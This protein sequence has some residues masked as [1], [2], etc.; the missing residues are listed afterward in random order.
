MSYKYYQALGQKA[1]NPVQANL[2]IS[3]RNPEFITILTTDKLLDKD[4][5]PELVETVKR[6]GPMYFDLDSKDIEESID[7]AK[8]LVKKLLE[9]G[10]SEDDICIHATG[11][12][13]FHILVPQSCFTTVKPVLRLH[14][15]YKEIAFKLATIATDF[16][17]YSGRMGR[18]WRTTYNQRAN[19]SF[20]VPV[21]HNELA[22]MTAE[23]YAELCSEQRPEFFQETG[24]FCP[25]FALVFDAALQKVSGIK[26][27]KA[28]FV[29]AQVMTQDAPAITRLLAGESTESYNQTFMQ[30][31]IY[32]VARGWTEDHLVSQATGLIASKGGNRYNNP[33]IIERELRNM[34]R[35][36]EGNSGYTYSSEAIR[37]L[38]PKKQSVDESTGELVEEEESFGPIFLTETAIF[39][40]GAENVKEILRFGVQSLRAVF[41]IPELIQKCQVE[42]SSQEQALIGVMLK[43][44]V[45]NG[46][47]PVSLMIQKSAF[48]GGG[49]LCSATMSAGVSFTGSDSDARNLFN[50]FMTTLRKTKAYT[51][52]A[53]REGLDLLKIPGHENPEIAQGFL[54]WVD[55]NGMKVRPGI[56]PD[57][58]KIEFK[59]L[60]DDITYNTDLSLLEP[61]DSW[62]GKHSSYVDEDATEVVSSS[63]N[64]E[65]LGLM[66]TDMFASNHPRVIAPILGWMVAAI[67]KQPIHSYD[68]KFPMLSVVGSAGLGKT[69]T[70]TTYMRLFY[71]NAEPVS[72]TPNSTLFG[73]QQM[74]MASASI[75]LICDEY[76]PSKMRA[77]KAEEFR[78]LLR[79]VY[80]QKQI[81]RGGGS[82]TNASWQG[83][84][85]QSLTA[86]MI[87]ISE[88]MET[89]S[90]IMERVV[91]ATFSK[92]NQ[93]LYQRY[94]SKY[95]SFK[96]RSHLL[97]HVGAEITEKLLVTYCKPKFDA[98]MRS[99]LAQAKDDYLP[100]EHL[101]A[102][103]NSNRFSVSSRTLGNYTVI[104]YGLSLLKDFLNRHFSARFDEDIERLRETVFPGM[105]ALTIAT[106]PEYLKLMNTF[107][108][109][110]FHDADDV[111]LRNNQEYVI[112]TTRQGKEIIDISVRYAFYR[113][114]L[115]CQKGGIS[116][117]FVSE[118]ALTSAM[119]NSAYFV[120]HGKGSTTS[121]GTSYLMDLTGMLSEGI[122]DFRRSIKK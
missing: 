75:P 113:Y 98:A 88:A 111:A 105:K 59:P 76:K 49:A 81:T 46:S 108:I 62:K 44:I 15:V 74:L 67:A 116:P 100:S 69:D 104:D 38:L 30:V 41:S 4:S 107:A 55:R 118:D 42:G 86:P 110:S 43:G 93:A 80:N 2:D 34:F 19:G 18:M 66:F 45:E 119:E 73:N 27:A 83:L 10:L 52:V 72:T 26:R 48:L 53:E 92:P 60:S 9:R 40:R 51:Y 35:Y 121:P 94:W 101:S 56:L 13:G 3:M 39:S 5:P 103:A 12:K 28:K 115:Y 17:V 64:L 117:L 37:D 61:F 97:A 16:R 102:E 8:E 90:A 57:N 11:S 91:L 89:E 87:V 79:E 1:W 68:G 23:S 7:C 120:N 99:A 14:E 24:K 29:S 36:L 84:N 114:R 122:T 47:G 109:M 21:T 63:T 70:I 96:R 112:T 54:A 85:K 58:L 20:K 78:A 50:L 32:A 22:E 25:E 82:R 77:E 33:R 31:A 65:E 106:L 71:K 6:T 95:E